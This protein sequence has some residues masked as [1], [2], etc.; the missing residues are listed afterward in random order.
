MDENLLPRPKRQNAFCAPKRR[1]V[2][3]PL[4]EAK[5]ARRRLNFEAADEDS[6][7]ANCDI[8]AD[9]PAASSD[10]PNKDKRGKSEIFFF[11]TVRPNVTKACPWPIRPNLLYFRIVNFGNILD[12]HCLRCNYVT[13]DSKE[14][15]RHVY[16]SLSHERLFNIQL[17]NPGEEMDRKL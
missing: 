3:Q 11:R 9:A 14:Y 10:N 1:L 7:A 6:P 4:F 2:L 5:C 16:F 17:K 8:P 12:Y 13:R 15:T